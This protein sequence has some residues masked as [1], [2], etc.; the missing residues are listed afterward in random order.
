M[1]IRLWAYFFWLFK[2]W[3]RLESVIRIWLIFRLL[4]TYHKFISIFARE[5]WVRFIFNDNISLKAERESRTKRRKS[6]QS[7][8][9]WFKVSK[10]HP[11]PKKGVAVL[12]VLPFERI[13][14]FA[15]DVGK[16][17][18]SNDNYSDVLACCNK[19]FWWW[20]QRDLNGST[21]RYLLCNKLMKLHYINHT[22]YTH[23]HSHTPASTKLIS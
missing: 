3:L 5:S 2:S 1:E 16:S 8:F 11:E 6:V 13:I 17:S 18:L 9:R 4:H 15:P 10:C 12:F 7:G 19:L 14:F 23:K 22:M 20:Q 21:N